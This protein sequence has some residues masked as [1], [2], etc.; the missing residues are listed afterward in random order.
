LERVLGD[1]AAALGG[2]FGVIFSKSNLRFLERGKS[3]SCDL[4]STSN[5]KKIDPSFSRFSIQICDESF[6]YE[7]DYMRFMIKSNDKYLI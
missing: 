4:L 6:Q 5:S 1:I 2:V 3:Q 7:F